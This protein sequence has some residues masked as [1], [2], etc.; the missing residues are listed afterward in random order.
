M[1]MEGG[2]PVQPEEEKER[3]N[4]VVGRRQKNMIDVLAKKL[5]VSKS[6]IVQGLL[7]AIL[8]PPPQGGM[9]LDEMGKFV[10][11]AEPIASMANKTEDVASKAMNL[12]LAVMSM[13]SLKDMFSQESSQRDGRGF[14]L[15][16]AFGPILLW[17][18]I[19]EEDGSR[20]DIRELL[21]TMQRDNEKRMESM[22]RQMIASQKEILNKF[23]E[24]VAEL[25]KEGEKS[26]EGDTTALLITE[27]VR[28][29]T[30]T[31]TQAIEAAKEGTSST[32]KEILKER[33]AL[34]KEVEEMRL[35]Q[36]ESKIDSIA[37]EMRERMTGEG[38]VDKI[39]EV[40]EVVNAVKELGGMSSG[41]GGE[42]PNPKDKVI[43]SLA[44]NVLPKIPDVIST[45]VESRGAGGSEEEPIP[46]PIFDESVDRVIM[47]REK[48]TEEKKVE[49]REE[50]TPNVGGRSEEKGAAEVFQPIPM[51]ILNENN[52]LLSNFTIGKR[53][54]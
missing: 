47:E 38:L 23:M 28:N 32:L 19:K 15:Q 54:E 52:K 9:Y 17:K 2:V 50:K 14:S 10:R 27:L 20:G 16:E 41:E 40:K 42:K 25:K 46:E 43:E 51:N 30:Q 34:R 31:Q 8:P 5:G 49:K 36:L 53:E 45:I 4:V 22:V 35:R 3:L 12:M 13:K 11:V 29:L 6:T 26:K 24:Q 21:I 1:E 33:D 37:Q 7:D 44:E 48:K 18:M 39:R